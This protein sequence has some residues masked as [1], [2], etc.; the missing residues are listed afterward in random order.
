VL[1]RLCGALVARTDARRGPA[2]FRLH[3]NAIASNAVVFADVPPTCGH[4][5]AHSVR[6]TACAV[7]PI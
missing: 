7:P 4:T 3:D 6:A 2:S 1:R 5:R